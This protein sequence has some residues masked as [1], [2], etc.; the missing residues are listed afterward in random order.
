MY[1]M[2]GLKLETILSLDYKKCGKLTGFFA[3]LDNKGMVSV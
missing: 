1:F 3:F 2:D